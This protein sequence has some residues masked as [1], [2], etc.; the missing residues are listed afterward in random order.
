M[1][2]RLSGRRV[3][4]VLA[5]LAALAAATALAPR[6]VRAFTLPNL[7]IS[8]DPVSVP[9]DHTLHVNILNQYNGNQVI[10]RALVKPTTPAAG[11][12][13]LGV[14]TILTPGDGSDQ[15]FPFA[16]FGPP[17]GANRV[18]VVVTIWVTVPGQSLTPLADWSAK[19]AT[20]VEVIEDATGRPI[21]NLG[22]RHVVFF[23][24]TPGSNFTFCLF[25]N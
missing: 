17:A 18:P 5:P 24:T 16:G 9:V 1:K 3:L 14:D 13:V 15:A 20:S 19:L 25:C 22:G 6:I 2:C 7:A 8:Y 11:Q 4:S 21:A 23:P 10:V 12:Q